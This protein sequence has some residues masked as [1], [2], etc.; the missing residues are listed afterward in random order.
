ML[1]SRQILAHYTLNKFIIEYNFFCFVYVMY[2][3][4][5]TPHSRVIKMHNDFLSACLS[6]CIYEQSPY[7]SRISNTG[8]KTEQWSCQ[9]A[10]GKPVVGAALCHQRWR[11]A[12]QHPSTSCPLKE[13][14]HTSS[15]P[16]SGLSRLFFWTLPCA[17]AVGLSHLVL[18][19]KLR[20]AK[21][22]M[23]CQ[24]GWCYGSM[25]ISQYQVSEPL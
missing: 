19:S 9:G 1:W 24:R 10:V 3:N 20:L 5:P 16:S 25:K 17:F 12:L 23:G 6:G 11:G 2:N 8:G 13:P 14:H 21:C 15:R 7:P 22:F 4:T 18:C